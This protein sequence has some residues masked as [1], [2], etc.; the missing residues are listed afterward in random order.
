MNEP[1]NENLF[2]D[3]IQIGNAVCTVSY[4]FEPGDPDD[5]AVITVS[6]DVFESVPTFY[7]EWVLPAFWK[8]RIEIIVNEIRTQLIE[9]SLEPET[10]VDELHLKLP[11]ANGAFIDTICSLLY[12][13]YEIIVY[14]SDIYKIM[15]T[16]YLWPVIKV[17]DR[18]GF[19][20]QL[21]I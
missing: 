8:Q 17:I 21:Y 9:I 5:G 3:T 2:P 7:W 11:N 4:L 15:Q 14:P 6:E 13:N 12:N 20:V 16:S 1:L 18:S 10:V 19:I